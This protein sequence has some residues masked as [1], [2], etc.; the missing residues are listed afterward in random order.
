MT[1]LESYVPLVQAEA[2]QL[3]QFLETLSADELQR[4]SACDAWEVRDVVAHLIWAADFYTDTVSR[5]LDGDTSLPEGRPPGDTSDAVPMSTYFAEHAIRRREALGEQL[6]PTLRT[7]YDALTDLLSKLHGQ[8]W[9]T[10]CA[11]FPHRGQLPARAFLLLT[12]QELTIHTWDIRSRFDADVA[13]AADLVPLL[14]DRIPGR[15]GMPEFAAFSLSPGNTDHARYRWHITG[16]SPRTYDLIVEHG[17][18]RMEPAEHD[19]AVD[20]TL[21]CDDSTFALLMYKRLTL[22]RVRAQGRVVVEGDQ[23]LTTALDDWLKQA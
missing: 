22:E 1:T 6:L 10:P 9:D 5:G 2:D 21:H 17:N 19:A 11:F 16:E 15:F 3:A 14:L 20:V 23:K 13:L 18:A 4:P 12:V 8:I 7:S